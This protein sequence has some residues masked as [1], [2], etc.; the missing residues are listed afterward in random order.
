MP[1][2]NLTPE[3]RKAALEK[4][5]Q[6]RRQRAEIK[7][8]LKSGELSLADALARAKK[9]PLI[10]KM[11]VTT[12]LS[13][14]PGIADAKTAALMNKIGISPTRRVAGLGQVQRRTLLEALS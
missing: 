10:G 5:A 14:L 1:V 9:D 3:Q 2:P 7:N 4:A 11:K 12:L 8:Q 6:V 13:S